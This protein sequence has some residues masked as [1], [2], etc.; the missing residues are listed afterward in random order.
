MKAPDYPTNIPLKAR[1]TIRRKG[2][3]PFAIRLS[4]E[5]TQS[6]ISKGGQVIPLPEFGAVAYNFR[7]FDGS[8]VFWWALKPPISEQGFRARFRAEVWKTVK[9]KPTQL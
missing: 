3:K 4:A 8:V 9:G 1:Q 2:G 6:G 5:H 7:W